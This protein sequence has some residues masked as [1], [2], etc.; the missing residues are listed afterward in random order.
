MLVKKVMRCGRLG[1]AC[2]SGEQQ[3]TGAGEGYPVHTTCH[4]LSGLRTSVAGAGMWSVVVVF[5]VCVLGMAFAAAALS[6]WY[7][8]L[9]FLLTCCT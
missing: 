6:Q 7:T 1:R 3:G 4:C 2:G 8:T 9:E 5:M